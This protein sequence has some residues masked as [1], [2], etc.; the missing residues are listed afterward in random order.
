MQDKPARLRLSTRIF[1]FFW[2]PFAFVAKILIELRW[3]QRSKL[4]PY[5]LGACIG[6][7]PHKVPPGEPIEYD[8]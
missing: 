5:V 8:S 3:V 6:R 7:W 2:T 1:D 4:A